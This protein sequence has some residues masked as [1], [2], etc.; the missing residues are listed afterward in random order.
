MAQPRRTKRRNRWPLVLLALAALVGVAAWYYVTEYKATQEPTAP[1][2]QTTRV[3]LGDIKITAS[4]AGNLLPAR[5]LSLGFRSGGFLV[6]VAVQVG[7]QVAAGDLLARLDD[8]DAQ[9]QVAQ[10]SAS[11]RLAE[12]K[13]AGL[14]RGADPAALATAHSALA[15]AQADLAKLLTPAGEAEVLAARENLR[16]AQDALA[17][18]QA[19]AD[20]EKVQI[21]KSNM[22]LA[23]INVRAAQAAYDRVAAR[24]DPGASKEAAELWQAT[25]N[26][27]K[28]QAEYQEVLA[29]PT[30]D[31]I[32]AARAK[33]ALSE[34]QLT[35]L[36]AGPSAEAQAAAEAKVA[37]AQAQLEGLLAGASAEDLEAAELGVALARYSLENAQRQLAGTALRAP[38]AGTVVA[39]AA[40]VSEAVGTSPLITLADLEAPVVRF[41]VEEADLIS[42]ATGHPVEIVFDALPD[43]VF[44]GEVVRVDPALV[45]VGNTPVVQ[46]W[47]SVD[48]ASQAVALPSGLTADVEIVAGEATGALLVPVQ[49]LRETTPGQY[50]VFVVKADGALELRPVEIG[51]RDFVNAQVL[52]GLQRNDVVSTGTVDVGDR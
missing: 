33:V 15:A 14:T 42:V 47:A 26:Y 8:A 25:T 41:W 24:G 43:L 35:N 49:A 7:D 16:S 5:E 27:E 50:A 48:L 19:G 44:A 1:A 17:L 4:G 40:D 9:A 22:T 28:A 32:A 12:L 52:S 20:P 3:R 38:I 31:A 34:A 36:L 37:Q 29:G 39:V 46:A 2:L 18:L 45:T 6:E 51:L 11:L 30:S 10:A 13:L 21:A 23:E